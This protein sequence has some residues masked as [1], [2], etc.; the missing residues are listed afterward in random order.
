MYGFSPNPPCSCFGYGYGCPP[1]PRVVGRAPVAYPGSVYPGSPVN[2]VNP[3]KDQLEA[4]HAI[5]SS[6]VAFAP[7]VIEMLKSRRDERRLNADL[8]LQL[9]LAG[10]ALATAAELGA[11]GEV[12]QQYVLRYREAM[13]ATMVTEPDAVQEEQFEAPPAGGSAVAPEYHSTDGRLAP[14]PVSASKPV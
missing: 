10:E 5:Q 4:V 3:A 7:L 2:P 9:E 13:A 1:G 6:L 12:L 11:K 14:S 8:R